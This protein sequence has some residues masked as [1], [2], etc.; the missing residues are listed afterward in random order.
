MVIDGEEIRKVLLEVIR[1]Q[2]AKDSMLQSGSILHEAQLRLGIPADRE[3]EQAFLTLFYDLFRTGYLSWGSNLANPA[4]PHCHATDQC[5][6]ALEQLSRDPANPAGYCKYLSEN[7]SIN[8]IAESYINEAL[9]SYNNNCFRAAAVMIGAAVE[10]IIL[11]LRDVLI[12]Q[13]KVK[14]KTP[15]KDLEDWKIKRVM[16]GL[17]KEFDRSKSTMP[18]TLMEDYESYWPAFNQQIRTA[19]NES[20][21]PASIAPVTHETVHAS[22]LIFPELARLSYQLESW[23]N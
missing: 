7:S 14:G 4:S 1:D 23:I 19:R 15:S 5:R 17:K 18:K 22:F 8:L 16:E 9:H 2:A 13:L 10:S 6:R 21:H 20:G 3:K 11:Q 12:S